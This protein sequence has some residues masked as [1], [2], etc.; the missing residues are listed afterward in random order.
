[1]N[2]NKARAFTLIELLVVIAIIAILTSLLLPGLARAK[3]KARQIS[4]VRNQR[5]LGLAATLYM[6]DNNGQ[7]FHHHEG[8]VLD[9]GS[10]LDELPESLAALSGGGKGNSQ[11]EKPWVIILQPYLKSRR[12]GFCPGDT[13]KKSERLSTTLLDY[14]GGIQALNQ[15]PPPGSELTIAEANHLTMESYLLNSIFTHRSARYA[16]EGVLNG[17]ATETAIS[18][19]PNPN[20][21]MFS[22]RN[23]EAMNAADNL[24]F[25]ST[26]QDDYDTWV[27][28]SALVKWGSG[29]Y[30]EQG[31]IK[32]D[33]H[34]LKANYVYT[35]G[36]VENLYWKAARS[37]QFPDHVVRKPLSIVPR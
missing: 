24:E 5:Q 13:T 14:N 19:L 4:C 37:D 15:E 23:S 33:R 29:K 9:D 11:A 26:G 12:V 16:L 6:G 1:M 36:H 17:F 32:H 35:D 2:R 31:W 8:W 30:S 22:E 34:Q 18:L 10:Q 3:S 21:I 25:G 20:V 28:E 7:M 27:G